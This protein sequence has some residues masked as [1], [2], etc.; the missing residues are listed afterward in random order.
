MKLSYAGCAAI[1]A[2]P[3]TFRNFLATSL[4]HIPWRSRGHVVSCARASMFISISGWRAGRVVVLAS[5]LL[6]ALGLAVPSLAA[7]SAPPFPLFYQGRESL[8]LHRLQLDPS[9]EAVESLTGARSAVY[10]DQ[11]PAPGPELD[12]LK[13]RLNDGMGLVVILGT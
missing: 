7:D 2:P 4:R 1:L 9:T 12:A 5:M 11:L 6:C 8:I 3:W 10:Q 13:V